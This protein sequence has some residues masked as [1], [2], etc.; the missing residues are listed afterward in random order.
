M[1]K[2]YYLGT[3]T[4]PGGG[5]RR[6]Y[7]SAGISC[8]SESEAYRAGLLHHRGL[9]PSSFI[10][11]IGVHKVIYTPYIQRGCVLYNKSYLYVSLYK[12]YICLLPNVYVCLYHK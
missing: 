8:K 1:A 5:D 9:I 11:Q 2:R 10:R 12:A 3:P 7:K 6:R 4:F